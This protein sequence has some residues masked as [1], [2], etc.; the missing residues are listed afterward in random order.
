MC[1]PTNNPKGMK[2]N[3]LDLAPNYAGTIMAVSNGLGSLPGFFAVRGLIAV[4]C[5]LN[6]IML[7]STSQP[8][9]IGLIAK[10][11][12]LPQ[13]RTVFYM[14]CGVLVVT[15]AVFVIWGSGKVQPWNDTRP[16]S[17]SDE[18]SESS[19]T[20]QNVKDQNKGQNVA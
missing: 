2:A 4:I 15:N 20:T 7:F 17:I 3:V 9:I 14:T 10:D 19:D 1:E 5:M 16:K 11:Q 6:I 13:W 18:T 12:T 8:Y